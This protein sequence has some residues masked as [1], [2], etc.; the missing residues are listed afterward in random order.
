MGRRVVFDGCHPVEQKNGNFAAL[1]RLC[2][3]MERNWMEVGRMSRSFILSTC[4]CICF[5]FEKVQ[6]EC[7]MKW[8]IKNEVEKTELSELSN[9]QIPYIIFIDNWNILTLPTKLTLLYIRPNNPRTTDV[10]D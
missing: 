2:H 8:K 1:R 10:W 3:P 9:L 7:K 6:E 4:F 5:S